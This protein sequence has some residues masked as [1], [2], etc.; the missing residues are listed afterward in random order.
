MDSFDLNLP[1]QAISDLDLKDYRE[2]GS[3]R[4]GRK[5]SDGVR[6]EG[7]EDL[8]LAS[9]EG[10]HA[11]YLEKYGLRLRG[12]RDKVKPLPIGPLT[13]KDIHWDVEGVDTAKGI[14]REGNGYDDNGIVNKKET[15]LVAYIPWDRVEDFV[16]GEESARKD[17]ETT[18]VRDKY[19]PT[20]VGDKTHFRWNRLLE[21]QR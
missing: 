6:E 8:E 19:D 17:V 11:L 10:P 13:W 2:K 20:N 14:K 4:Q 12:M 5:K 21:L 15:K 1:A 16:M 18:F 9:R 3:R 7:V